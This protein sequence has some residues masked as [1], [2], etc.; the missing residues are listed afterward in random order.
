MNEQV[1]T[2]SQEIK[3][4]AQEILMRYDLDFEIEKSPLVGHREVIDEE[5]QL[6]GIYEIPSEYA[7]LLNTQSGEIIN[8]V[9]SGYAVAQNRNFIELA[10]AG[11]DRFDVDTYVAKAG[12][13]NGGRRV[14]I[15]FGLEGQAFNGDT[16]T[17]YIMIINSNDGH[18]FS[19]GVGEQVMSCMNQFF[20]FHKSAQSKFSHTASLENRLEEIP[21]LL[22]SALQT[23]GLMDELYD[24]M[25]RTPCTNEMLDGLVK[26]MVGISYADDLEALEIGT[27]KKNNMDALYNAIYHEFDCKGDNLWGLFNGITYW[28][29]YVKKH[30]K[31]DNGKLESLVIGTGQ[32]TNQKALDYIAKLVGFGEI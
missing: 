12:V 3:E 29:N 18:K 23:I 15:Q 11:V 5:N 20:S 26:H 2:I 8:S 6:V 25:Y 30:P 16:I 21:F 10:L 1:N 9:K 22:E 13:L 17:R 24:T 7:G 19:V 28:T 27:R 32:R 4:R 14:F 31:R